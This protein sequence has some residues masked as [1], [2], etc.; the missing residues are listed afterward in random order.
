MPVN[1]ITVMRS[2]D[3]IPTEP[4]IVGEVSCSYVN[5]L[6]ISDVA[7]IARSFER[8]VNHNHQRGYRLVTFSLHRMMTRPDELNETIMAVFER[9]PAPPVTGPPDDRP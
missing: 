6:P 1:G 2:R 8:L 9:C 3:T 4:F 7:P 5:G